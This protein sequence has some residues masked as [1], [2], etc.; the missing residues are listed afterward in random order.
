VYCS[1]RGHDSLAVFRISDDF[2]LEL[3]SFVSLSEL[4]VKWPRNFAL[5]DDE[6]L[7]VAG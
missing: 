1:N 7:L 4:G 6:W 2:L 5:I 3:V